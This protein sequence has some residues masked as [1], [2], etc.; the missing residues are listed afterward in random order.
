MSGQRKNELDA[1]CL[2]LRR[3]LI[4]VLHGIQTGHP[5]GSLSMTEILVTLYFEKLRIDPARPGDPGRDRFILSKGH[6]AP[7]LYEVLAERGFFPREDL[8]SLRQIGSHLQGH[9]CARK[10][11]G[12]ELSTGPLGLGLSAGLGMALAARL[13]G[14]DYRTYVLMGDGELQ[15]GIVWEGAMSAARFAA[16][17]LCVIVDYNGVQLDG[18]LDEVMPLGDLSAKW[19]AFGWQVIEVDDG[20]DLTQLSDAIDQAATTKGRPVVI[21]ARTVKGK[22]VSFMEGESAWHGKPIGDDDY[23]KAMKELGVEA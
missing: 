18:T 20:H 15:E 4:R 7:M 21:L 10:T 6:G 16:D 12:I 5:G 1:L 17:R 23:A 2:R 14:R 3:D 8:G 11:P 13:D 22:G 19:R 9:P